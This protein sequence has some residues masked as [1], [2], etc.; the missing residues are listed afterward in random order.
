MIRNAQ[1]ATADLR[2][3][4]REFAI[5]A[6]QH[7]V[8]DVAFG[9]RVLEVQLDGSGTNTAQIHK[10]A[11]GVMGMLAERGWAVELRLSP[12]SAVLVVDLTGADT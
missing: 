7:V 4:T 1:H 6:V 12:K 3:V 2:T 8:L 9:R 5:I 10:A 11:L